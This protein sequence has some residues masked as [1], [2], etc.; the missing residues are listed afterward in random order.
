MNDRS[1]QLTMVLAVAPLTVAAFL[2][3][4][5]LADHVAGVQTLKFAT[6]I[7]TFTLCAAVLWIWR[8]YV[9]WNVV[10][11]STTAAL[12]VL[13]IGQVLVWRPMWHM[14]G[15]AQDDIL[16]V[17]QSLASAGLWCAGCGLSWWGVVLL[18]RQRL[19]APLEHNEYHS[20]R[21]VMSPS[22]VRLAI[23]FALIPFLPGLFFTA[24]LGVRSFSSMGET[25]AMGL[26]YQ[27]CAIVAVLVWLLLW[28]GLVSWTRA[29][30]AWTWVLAA[31][32]LA[33]PWSVFLPGGSDV[34]EMFRGTLP[35]FVLAAWFGGTAIVWRSAVGDVLAALEQ[36]DLEVDRFIHCPSCDYSL[37]GLREVRCPECGWHSTVDDI[38]GRGLSALV[39][40]T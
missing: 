17:A 21:C 10:R 30:W 6:M 32:V 3:G 24:M 34:W 29:R 1:A 13:V 11:R 9:R 14:S 7:A 27:S 35:L 31:L 15:C 16:R 37:R 25:G 26:A 19:L 8:R 20:Q 22:T 40:T 23:G 38:V 39:E 28:R 12:T 5:E 4:G 36:G 2:V 18:R 33:V